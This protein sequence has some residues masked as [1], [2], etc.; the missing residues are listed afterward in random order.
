MARATLVV[1]DPHHRVDCEKKLRDLIADMRGV[2]NWDIDSNGR[3]TVDYEPEETSSNIIEEALAGIGYRIEHVADS[4]RLGKADAPNLGVKEK[5]D[6]GKEYGNQS[7][8]EA[9]HRA[10]RPEQ[11]K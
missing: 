5:T 1:G 3:V 4:Q 10:R 2:T 9:V 6:G 8:V 7:N 11:K